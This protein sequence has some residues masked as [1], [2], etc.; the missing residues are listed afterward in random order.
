MTDDEALAW[1]GRYRVAFESSLAVFQ[2]RRPADLI[3]FD[4]SSMSPDEIA[5][6]LI[7]LIE[8]RC[9]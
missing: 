8:A 6:S 1:L 3:R 9:G 4:T 7:D 5:A 2:Q